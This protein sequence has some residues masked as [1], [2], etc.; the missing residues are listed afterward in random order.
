MEAR[1]L[2]LAMAMRGPAMCR[3]LVVAVLA[4]AAAG[5]HK[6]VGHGRPDGAARRAQ[7]DGIPELERAERR[8]LEETSVDALP[9]EPDPS[10]P[11]PEPDAGSPNGLWRDRNQFRR[12]LGKEINWIDRYM[13]DLRTDAE[14]LHGVER[15]E[16][17]H[18]VDVAREWQGRLRGDL[19]AI[20]R[21]SSKVWPALK[22]QIERDLE[23]DHPPSIPRSYEKAYGI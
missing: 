17:L 11:E 2:Q 15:D 19:E 16:K 14:A 22:E 20:G 12:L 3:I 9:S 18:D 23:E 10:A 21:V 5:C 1:A 7:L 6:R 13:G 8:V 4:I